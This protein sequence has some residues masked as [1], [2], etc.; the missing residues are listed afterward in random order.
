MATKEK[1][2]NGLPQD[3]VYGLFVPTK[4]FAHRSQNPAK[5][6]NDCISRSV[7][8]FKTIQPNLTILAS[9]SSAEDVLSNNVKEYDIF[10]LQVLKIRRSAFLGHVAYIYIYIYI[11]IY[12]YTQI[13]R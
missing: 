6:E 11:D 1:R 9:F 10:G 3:D 13:N 5:F 8:R 2:N 4:F 12:I 7:H